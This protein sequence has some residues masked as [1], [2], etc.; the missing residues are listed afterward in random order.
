MSKTLPSM[1]VTENALKI[2]EAVK[3]VQNG[4]CKK[5]DV[6]GEIKVYEVK[7]VIR[8]DIKYEE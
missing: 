5:V 4:L 3:A 2:V 8:I 6:N 7:N 1:I